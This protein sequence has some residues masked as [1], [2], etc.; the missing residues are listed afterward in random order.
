MMAQFELSPPAF[1]QRGD[2]HYA[3]CRTGLHLCGHAC[4]PDHDF[5][6]PYTALN[7]VTN[8]HQ[9]ARQLYA[10]AKA[11]AECAKHE[12]DF[13]LDLVIGNDIEEGFWTNRQLL[14]RLFAAAKG[15]AE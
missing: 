15:E 11:E 3:P 7:I 2:S 14:P 5:E 1:D 12:A 8:T 4:A 9:Q 10:R 6:Q 13:I